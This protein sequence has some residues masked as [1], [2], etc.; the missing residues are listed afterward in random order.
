[1][2]LIAGAVTAVT[3]KDQ[4]IRVKYKRECQEHMAEVAADGG[5]PLSSADDCKNP[6]DYMPWWDVLVAWPEGI[7]TWAILL[8]L[9]AISWQAFEARKATAVAQD[10]VNAAYGSLAYAEAQFELMKEKE[11]PRLNLRPAEWKIERNGQDWQIAGT[12]EIKNIGA[13][14]AFNMECRG[15]LIV[16]PTEQAPPDPDEWSGF[17][18]LPEDYIDPSP[19]PVKAE[20]RACAGEG[21]LPDDL[22]VFIADALARRLKIYIVGFIEYQGLGMKWRRPFRYARSFVSTWDMLWLSPV[23]STDGERALRGSWLPEIEDTEIAVS[24]N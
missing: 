2:V 21:S 11:R 4:Q 14:R 15:E 20:F 7:T 3:Y 8:T 9:G 17:I 19:V 6:E 16:L 23:L 18:L 24:Q 1:M 22:D 5:D 13:G 12:V 10:A